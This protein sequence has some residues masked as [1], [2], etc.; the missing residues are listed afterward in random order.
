MKVKEILPLELNF[1]IKNF[2]YYFKNK[3]LRISTCRNR[4]F[5]LDAADYDNCGDLAIAEG[6]INFTKKYFS[7]QEF[8]VI[9]QSDFLQYFLWLK[10]EIN[11]GDMIFLSGGGNMGTDYP[12]FEAI[13]RKVI[14]NFPN[15]KIIIFPSTLDYHNSSYGKKSFTN[16]I[17]TYNKNDKVK[18]F[19]RE[20]KTYNLLIKYFDK[21]YIYLSPDIV[22]FLKDWV[23][24]NICNVIKN[25]HV[26]VCIRNDAE[27]ILSDTSKERLFKAIANKN[28]KMDLIDTMSSPEKYDY[29]YQKIVK[30]KIQEFSKYSLIITDRLHA[31]VFACLVGVP[32]IAF[33]NSNGKVFG[34]C[35]RLNNKGIIFTGV[36][37]N[38][39]D[40]ISSALNMKTNFNYD[41]FKREFDK[42]AKEI[43]GIL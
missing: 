38:F 8:L 9:R 28:L 30:A 11:S 43:R 12:R 32:C 25:K 22:F 42:M 3:K 21:N 14:R 7:S 19:A 4:I 20:E 35:K 15:N 16:A 18:I 23:D 2:S 31:V 27:S 5:Y 33:D 39:E 41:Y 37:D 36:N 10:K 34:V 1:E 17:K 40:C 6:I 13:R 29:Q 24:E 26:G